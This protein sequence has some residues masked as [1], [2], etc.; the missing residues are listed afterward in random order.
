MGPLL[1]E[2]RLTPP[3][4]TAFVSQGHQGRA[5]RAMGLLLATMQHLQ[6][7]LPG[8]AGER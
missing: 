3:A 1:A 2:V 5:Q 4:T 8:G 7:S 6:R